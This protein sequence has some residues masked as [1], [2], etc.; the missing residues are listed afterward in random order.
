MVDPQEKPDQGDRVPAGIGLALSGGG[1]RGLAHIGVLKVLEREKVP[2]ACLAGT[3]MGGIVGAV[4]AAGLSPE[5]IEAEALCM[6]RTRQLITLV[7]RS[8]LRRGLLSGHKVMAYLA[9]WLGDLTFGDLRLPL[10]LVAADL[11]GRE[12][13]VFREGPVLEAVRATMA[14]PGLFAPV[15]RE[16]QLLVDGGIVDN[17]PADVVREMGAERVVAVDISTDREAVG[18]VAE[19]LRRRRLVPDG[20][21]DMI[22]LLGRSL[23]F[24]TW[25][26]NR[27]A[28]EE[29]APDLV[30]RPPVPPTVMPITGFSQAVEAIA[31][32]ERAAQEAMPQIRAL[33]K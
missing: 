33:L 18:F 13:V 30:I 17:L 3:S 6:S 12:K 31:A 16:D 24:L 28:L 21:A 1:A 25:E 5:Q 11:N 22:D 10:A 4:Y 9:Q 19:N 2:I 8:F 23:V 15:E 7:D 32:G 26:V 29:A 27:R 14:L 20:L